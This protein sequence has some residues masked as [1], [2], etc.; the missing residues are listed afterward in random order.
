MADRLLRLARHANLLPEQERRRWD[1][2]LLALDLGTELI[3]LRACLEGARGVLRKARD[4]FLGELGELLE[5]GPAGPR[6]D[7]LE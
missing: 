6:S 1:D 2:G 5:A 7:R 4:R 3:H